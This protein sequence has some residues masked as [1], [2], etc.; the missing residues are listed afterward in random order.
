M[1]SRVPIT[2]TNGINVGGI[3]SLD[4]LLHEV[5]TIAYFYKWTED[6]ILSLTSERRRKYIEL[7][8]AQVKAESS[9]DED[10]ED[11]EDD[12]EDY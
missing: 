9:T 6:K 5:H 1:W 7:I 12:Y 4:D 8:R 11:Y 10:G 2:S 3:T